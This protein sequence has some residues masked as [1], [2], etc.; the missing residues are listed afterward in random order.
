MEKG[1][2]RMGTRAPV[3]EH[4]TSY[5]GSSLHDLNAGEVDPG[6]D[7]ITQDSLD[8]DGESSVVDCMQESY[9]NS[10]PIHS[11]GVESDHASLENS[12]SS[13][14]SHSL[15]IEDVSPI[16][17]ARARFLDVIVDNFICPHMV[18]S[19]YHEAEYSG[20][21]E[22]DKLSKRRPHEIQYEGDAQHVLPLMYVANMYE[23][24]VN[25]V[26]LRLSS[27]T[28][29]REKTIGVA[30]E[31]AGGLYRKLAKKFPR[32]GPYM[33]R[34]RELAT[35]LETRS[36]FPELV[37]QE[38]KRVRFVVVN[39]LSI[40]EKP[41][42]M[43]VNDFEWFQRL[44]GRNE[45]AVSARDYKFYAPRP[46]FRRV[47][48]SSIP[49]LAGLP[50]FPDT[51]DSSAMSSGQGYNS[52]NLEPQNM[53]Q[54][55]SKRHL[56]Q[57]LSHQS[58]FSPLLQSNEHEIDQSQHAAHFADSQQCGPAH[59]TELAHGPHSSTITQQMACLQTLGH[60]GGRIH[61][62]PSSPAKFCDECGVPFLR[63]TS[64]FCSECGTKRLGI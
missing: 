18:P 20:Q 51:D 60:V 47:S 19:S 62:L 35:S 29:M 40:V 55:S 27:I 14:G 21:S 56:H 16:E 1:E 15:T 52:V 6:G 38:E 41:L 30:L 11:V 34:R 36:R 28:G 59:L 33:F 61:V 5:M 57:Q 17:T 64:K 49:S 12:G 10:L 24:L 42:N 3:V 2:S 32:K 63:E 53:Q 39:G 45:V 8:N 25:D 31:A 22:Q 43:Q 50:V 13:G 23:T 4:Y 58:Q 7:D 54:N 26:N 37:V 9:R 44:T 46:K 48:S